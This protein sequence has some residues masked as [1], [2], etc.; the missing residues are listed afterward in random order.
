MKILLLAMPNVHLGFGYHKNLRLPNI[1]LASLAGNLPSDCEVKIADLVL[2]RGDLGTYVCSLFQ[3][4][5]PDLV[6]FSCMTF[7]YVTALRLA[8]LVKQVNPA[9]IT[10]FGGYHPTL[11]YDELIHSAEEAW[12][13]YIIRN[14]GEETFA[15]LV[16]ALQQGGNIDAI[17][18]LSYKRDGQFIHNPPNG[19]L[20]LRTVQLPN[21]SARL[22]TKGFHFFGLPADAIE[23]SRGCPYQC[24]FC[25]I[26]KMYGHT[27]RT[28][29]LSR[30]I[31][32][33]RDAHAHGSRALFIVDDNITVHVERLQE[34]CDCF[35]AEGV[36]DIHYFVQAGVRGIASSPDVARKMAKAGF[37]LVFLGI[38][39]VSEESLG[40]LKARTKIGP[41][42]TSEMEQTETAVAYLRENGIIVMGGFILG[43]PDDTEA[44]FWANEQ[45]A[46][47][48]K[49]D[50]P[51]FFA[52]TPYPK[53]VLRQELLA[54]N[55]IVNLHDYSWYH[56]S[57]AN[58]RTRHLTPEEVDRLLFTLYRRYFDWWYLRVTHIWKH[59]PLY[60]F[61][62]IIVPKLM[63]EI[64]RRVLSFFKPLDIYRDIVARRQRWL[65]DT[66][67]EP[68]YNR[69]RR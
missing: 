69:H 63:I 17:S 33:I 6:G 30:I 43:N 52:L 40:F 61:L 66:D 49:L 3:T 51:F 65:L 24:T 27:V 54:Q 46:R 11:V 31:S 50:G 32:D 15:A 58:V 28:Y 67:P 23:T 1:G 16:H 38:E 60:F 7:Q 21:R 9:T 29:E 64:R 8:Q 44:D 19:L 47:Q 34:L 45:Y 26:T 20:D 14:E 4:Y 22:L 37:K 10:V 57:K 48:L 42:H 56:P 5:T 12:I 25:C 2:V 35:I 55:L 62:H 41:R 53:T 36:N 68:S 39:N 59:Y 13:D 18:G